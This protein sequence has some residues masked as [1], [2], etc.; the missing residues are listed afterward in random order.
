MDKG[1]F[2]IRLQ[3]T[4]E[5]V[6][7]MKLVGELDLAASDQ[8]RREIIGSDDVA[9]LVVD[10]TEL[11]FID[12]SGLAALMAGINELGSARFELIPGRAT[13]RLLRITD[14]KEMFGI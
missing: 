7:V 10:T 5:G 3:D 11:T 6:R 4:D 14:T 13:E 2:Q 12:S 9:R 8:V 1:G